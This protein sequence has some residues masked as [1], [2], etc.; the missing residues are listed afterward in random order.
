MRIKNRYKIAGLLLALAFLVFLPNKNLLNNFEDALRKTTVIEKAFKNNAE[1]EEQQRLLEQKKQERKIKQEQL[2]AEIEAKLKINQEFGVSIYDI[3]NNEAFGLNDTKSFHAAS[4]MKTLVATAAY[5]EVEAGKYKLTTPLGSSTYQYQI[6]QMINQSNNVS[7][8]LFN[9]LLGFKREQQ[10]ADRLGLTGVVVM[11][12]QM[13]TK[14][15]SE[16]LLKLYKGE[17][18][19]QAHRDQFFSFMQNTETENRIS[20]SIPSGVT[21]YHKTGTFEGGL[22]DAAIIIHPKNPFILVVFTKDLQGTP[23]ATRFSSI[24]QAT[25]SIYNYF[26]SI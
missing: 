11:G 4:V 18:L 19:T 26:S 3:N 16:L 10:T 6:Q 22:H 7:W 21:F 23:H 13:T 2:L 15:V 12:N 20:P 1:A 14:G 8:D 9:N 25:T 24:Q 5:E 17:V